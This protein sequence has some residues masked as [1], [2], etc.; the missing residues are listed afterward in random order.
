MSVEKY[1]LL[2]DDDADIRRLLLEAFADVGVEVVAVANCAD[3][4]VEIKRAVPAFAIVDWVLPDA[5]G[6][7]LLERMRADSLIA[8]PSPLLKQVPVVLMSGVHHGERAEQKA[9]TLG[10]LCFMPKPLGVSALVQLVQEKLAPSVEATTTTTPSLQ[11]AGFPAS[12]SASPLSITSSMV[13][14]EG[15]LS[16]VPCVELL[17][18]LLQS[19]K[20]GTLLVQKGSHKKVVYLEGDGNVAAIKSNIAAESLGRILLREKWASA[21]AVAEALAS[22]ISDDDGAAR[23]GDVLVQ[24]G[25]L[26]TA[27]LLHALQLQAEER[28]FD[29]LTWD[30]GSY[31]FRT[32]LPMPD[33][34]VS[35]R[36]ERWFPVLQ[37][38]ISQRK[39]STS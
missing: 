29:L 30:E 39:K 2:V 20:R 31:L 28:F 12:S 23:Q 32:E 14:S 35:P 19:R 17:W 8:P 10:A 6:L 18:G 27:T 24:R 13:P 3:A 7:S 34:A 21:E 36:K 22:A 11:Q 16:R 5:T 15:N 38:K 9:A 4:W 33:R 25:F 1:V 26:S 37:E